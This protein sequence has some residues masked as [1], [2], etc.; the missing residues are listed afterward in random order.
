MVLVSKEQIS[1]YLRCPDQHCF[2]RISVYFDFLS[3]STCNSFLLGQYLTIFYISV[4]L[5]FCNRGLKIRF[6]FF[7]KLFAS[8][9]PTYVTSQVLSHTWYFLASLPAVW[10]GPSDQNSLDLCSSQT[11]HLPL[12]HPPGNWDPIQIA[13]WFMKISDCER[14]SQKAFVRQS[15]KHYWYI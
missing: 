4:S 7:L 13:E 8:C 6:F 2:L 11:C 10:Q 5:H 1:S 9:S 14:W 3:W 15:D 12:L